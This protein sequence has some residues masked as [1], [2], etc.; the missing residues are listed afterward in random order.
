MVADFRTIH[1]PPMEKHGQLIEQIAAVIAVLLL[2]GGCLVIL[3]PFFAA[4]LWAAIISFCTW[5]IY[6]RLVQ[7]MRGQRGIAAFIMMLCAFF[8]V[9]G[10]FAY[11]IIGLA[12]H[13][14]LLKE[15]ANR[16]AEKGALPLPDWIANLPL[17]GEYLRTFWTELMKGNPQVAEFARIKLGEPIGQWT[18]TL[19]AAAGVGLMQLILSIFLTFFFYLSGNV[20][21]NWLSAAIRRLAGE[22]GPHLLQLAGSTIRGVVYGILGTALVQAVLAGFGYW[23]A[24]VPAAGIWGFATFFLSVVPLGP[25]LIWVP[26]A[27]WL[28]VQGSTAWCVF[29]LLWGAL[30]V[31]S[32]DNVI[33]PLIISR[34]GEMPF[35]IV[36]LGVLGGA[37]AFGFLGLFIGPTL[38]AVGYS[39]LRDWTV[40]AQP[41]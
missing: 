10:P 9:G 22:R 30:V 14:A 3:A 1:G 23:I 29:M 19:V 21:V 41:H 34:G 33:K 39:M 31:S 18:L 24:G 40:G 17:V 11:A 16:L 26:A 4:L 5:N 25:A 38:L 35:I 36:L 12:D 6:L 20:A 8:C 13:A 7:L 37:L 27:I 15:L 2:I 32:A 28:Y